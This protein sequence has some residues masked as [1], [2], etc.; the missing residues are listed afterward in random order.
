MPNL[1]ISPL[2]RGLESIGKRGFR[3]DQE[4]LKIRL[5]ENGKNHPKQKKN[6]KTSRNMSKLEIHPLTIGLKS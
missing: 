4:Y 6:S 1:A 2:T 5:F 3:V